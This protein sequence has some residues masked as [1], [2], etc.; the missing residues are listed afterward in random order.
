M[1]SPI[2]SEDGI[3]IYH[4]DIHDK[5]HDYNS[6]GLDIIHSQE[7]RHFWFISRKEFI[8]SQMKPF[9]P[10]DCRIMEIG[11]GTGNVTRYLETGGF[12][13]IAAGDIHLSGLKYARAYG[14]RNCYQFDLLRTP[15]E[16]EFEAVCMFDVLEHLQ[17]EDKALLNIHR[18]LTTGGRIVLT[19][20]AHMWLWSRDDR[21]ASHKRRYTRK[22]LVEKLGKNGYRVL[23]ARYFFIS[24]VPLLW[25]R[26]IIKRDNNTEVKD[27][28]YSA[29]ISLKPVL[30][31]ILLFS[32]RIENKISGYLPNLFGG[33]LLIIAEKK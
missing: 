8:I 10:V 25:L 16:N 22:G 23:R 14:I 28:E 26:T 32:S 20:P 7:E 9:I 12:R 18:M 13:N 27:E 3:V 15:F 11:A 17:E 6:Q 30:N 33:S 19:V 24:I 4:D 29:D 31:R 1:N 21:I 5:H 2:K